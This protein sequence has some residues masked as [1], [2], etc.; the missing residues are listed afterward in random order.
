MTEY[1]MPE[2][3]E[4]YEWR[5]STYAD[6]IW[7]YLDGPNGGYPQYRHYQRVST[8]EDADFNA[9]V[10][11]AVAEAILEFK[12]NPPP[13]PLEPSFNGLTGYRRG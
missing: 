4:G 3:P 9:R 11:V 6:Y 1:K 7:V 13:A 10:A 5:V 2:P 12:N 8:L